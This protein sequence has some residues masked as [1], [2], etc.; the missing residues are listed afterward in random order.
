MNLNI[1]SNLIIWVVGSVVTATFGTRA[2]L[3]Y[4]RINS[5]LSKYFSITGY[6]VGLAWMLWVLPFVIFNLD[7]PTGRYSS[8][9][10]IS[11]GDAFLFMAMFTQSYIYWYLALQSTVKYVYIAIPAAFIAI[12][13]LVSSVHAGF[14]SL[15]LPAI[16]DGKAVF[17]STSGSHVS[18]LILIVFVFLIGIELLKRAARQEGR[19]SKSGSIA[20]SLLYICVGLAGS[21]N[22]LSSSEATN[23]SPIVIVLYGIG[24]AAFTLIF[25]VFRILEIKKK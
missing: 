15:D 4:R 22:I 24:M 14:S 23:T 8:L 16:I 11:L 3:N 18:Q 20:I 2:Y 21:V 19:K 5:P 7:E 12:V 1:P 6:L 10:L 25:L 9:I 17:P 13:G